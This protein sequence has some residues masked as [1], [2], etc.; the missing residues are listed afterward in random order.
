MDFVIHI[1]NQANCKQ[2]GS[3]KEQDNITSKTN[4]FFLIEGFESKVEMW[5]KI[6]FQKKQEDIL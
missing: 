6:Y 3:K 4:F 2:N 5:K 1:E